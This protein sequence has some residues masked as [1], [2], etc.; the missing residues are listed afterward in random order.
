[1]GA[2]CWV[3][4]TV[5]AMQHP[6]DSDGNNPPYRR[7][8]GEE[9]PAEEIETNE[10]GTN[11]ESRR[12]PRRSARRSSPPSSSSPASASPG[13]SVHAGRVTRRRRPVVIL[14]CPYQECNRQFRKESNRRTHMRVHT[15]EEPYSCEYEGCGRSFRWKSS[16]NSHHKV[17]ERNE[18]RA[19]GI[20]ARGSN[21][22]R[23]ATGAIVDVGASHSIGGSRLSG[24]RPGQHGGSGSIARTHG[25]TARHQTA[26]LPPFRV[27]AGGLDQ[28]HRSHHAVASSSSSP[29]PQHQQRGE[30]SILPRQ[31]LLPLRR[32]NFSDQHLEAG[33]RRRP[34]PTPTPSPLRHLDN[35]DSPPMPVE[36]GD[37]TPGPPVSSPRSSGSR[38]DWLPPPSSLNILPSVYPS[39]R[40]PVSHTPSPTSQWMPRSSFSLP[41]RQMRF[42]NVPPLLALSTR[43]QARIP[44][45]SSLGIPITGIR[46]PD[47]RQEPYRTEPLPTTRPV[48]LVVTSRSLRASQENPGVRR[49]ADKEIRTSTGNSSK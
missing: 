13:T 34:T 3:L 40:Q 10:P 17:H 33:M 2:V 26:R 11:R 15:R 8:L 48:E 39:G 41:H 7:S 12:T 4:R 6:D 19:Q 35:E 45:P 16:L 29:L 24:V 30:E 31:P 25:M 42:V 5:V 44:S 47:R 21:I 43:P 18:A 9:K 32:R 46:P 20:E 22:G 27:I 28:Q 1:M 14:D 23:T 38:Q 36:V 49:E 37:L